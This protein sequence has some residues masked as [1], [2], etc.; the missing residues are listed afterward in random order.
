MKTLH[1]AF[2]V[3][4]GTWF[5]EGS[6][7]EACSL[8]ELKKLLNP[9]KFVGYHPNGY[10]QTV[11]WPKTQSRIIIN[12]AKS[13]QQSFQ[14]SSKTAQPKPARQRMV[15]ESKPKKIG[16]SRHKFSA[17]LIDKILTLWV[18][19][20]EGP[21]IGRRLGLPAPTTAAVTV[22]RLRKQGNPRALARAPGR[23]V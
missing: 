14:S 16:T 15:D 7:E 18:A 4:T 5:V 23:I 1:P 3:T 13:L 8:K 9:C 22:A 21:E 2:D 19:G 17:E 11:S 20:V 10:I 6:K 12:G